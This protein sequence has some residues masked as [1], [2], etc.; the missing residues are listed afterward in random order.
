MNKYNLP[1]L[2][3]ASISTHGMK[4]VCFTDEERENQYLT[5]LAFYLTHMPEHQ[6]VFAE[7][8]GW[9]L[10][11]F[12]DKLTTTTPPNYLITWSL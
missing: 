8:S 5:T 11:S 4:G 9:N 7:N 2:L 1:V 10:N 6:F 12:R 3:T